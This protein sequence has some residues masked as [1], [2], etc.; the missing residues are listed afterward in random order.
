MMKPQ[1]R[2]TSIAKAITWR[3]IAT[4]TTA[5]VAYLVTGE[6]GTALHIGGVACVIK[7]VLYYGHERIW[8]N[9]TNNN[10][11]PQDDVSKH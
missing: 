7:L 11:E 10:K 8:Q 4:S 6:V 2:L 3:S 1:S 5:I 9:K